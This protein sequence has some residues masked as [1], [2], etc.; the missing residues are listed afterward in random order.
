M[1]TVMEKWEKMM[2]GIRIAQIEFYEKLSIKKPE[3]KWSDIL[4]E[5]Q[6]EEK[7][8]ESNEMLYDK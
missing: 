4:M 5:T 8:G 7:I 6:K 2:R 3:N 1:T